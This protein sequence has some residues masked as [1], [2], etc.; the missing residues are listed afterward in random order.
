MEIALAKDLRMGF[1]HYQTAPIAY[2]VE[3]RVNLEKF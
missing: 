1:E 2:G 3:Y